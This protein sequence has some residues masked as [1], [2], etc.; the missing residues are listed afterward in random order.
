MATINSLGLGSG[1]LTSDVI[2]KLKAND[3]SLIIKPIENKITLETQKKSALDLLKSLMT[4][5]KSS[6]NA[7]DDDSLYQKRSVSGTNSA[8]TVT[9]EAGVAVQSFSI[10]DTVLAQKNVKQSGSF[11]SETETISS[12][13]G[14][15]TLSIDGVDYSID[16]TATTTLSD[17]QEAIN[18]KMLITDEEGNSV[19]KVKASIL[20]VGSGDYRLILTSGKT[21]VTENI[22][23]S[24]SATGTLN[25]QLLPY[26]ADNPDGSDD[27]IIDNLNG[28]QDIQAARDS[29]FKFNGI[30]ITR[31]S[32]SID[33][34]IT[35]VTINMLEESTTGANIAITQDVA[36]ISDEMTTFVQNYNTLMS[37]LS[38]MTTSDTEAG[39]V[40][41][42]NGDSSINSIK[43][44]VN[45]LI[46][47]INT[48]GYSLANFGID[49][50]QDGVMSFNSATFTTEFNKDTTL[51]EK[52]FSGLTTTTDG[53][54]ETVDGV[55]TSM[56]TLMERYLDSTGILTNLTSSVTNEIKTLGENKTRS[57]ALLD[58]RYESMTARF[59]QY[60]AI[61]SKL[62]N[63]FSSLQQQINMA[64]N[65]TS[66]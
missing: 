58:A 44:E 23:L 50:S 33:D 11:S 47:S 59:I 61:I 22:T 12:G 55:Y 35:G 1:V 6:V 41:V 24:D 31:S 39:T 4:S 17:L 19:Q 62:E 42:L 53:N 2:D 65:G 18:A 38:D 32:N 36:A 29:T 57:Q 49:L 60:D 16:Y 43:R 40:G 51:S 13:S 10:T 25:E 21:G 37:E 46:T 28:M 27:G 20:Q 9:A 26:N 8:V 66:S 52:F 45:K 15:M 14:S 7:L 64:V 54:I 3:T 63:Q 34:I 56:K 30:S 5:F 48:D